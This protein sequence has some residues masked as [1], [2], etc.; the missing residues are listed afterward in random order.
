LKVQLELVPF[1]VP[2][3][4]HWYVYGEV[5][6]ETVGLKFSDWLTSMVVLPEGEML[7]ESDVVVVKD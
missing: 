2:F 4:Y 3:K 1:R 5:P 6:P 7:Q